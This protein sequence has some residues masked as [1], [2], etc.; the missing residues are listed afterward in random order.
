MPC[1]QRSF[2]QR[3]KEAYTTEL[4]EFITMVRAGRSSDQYHLEQEAI[5]R[6]SS[7]ARITVAAELS[8]KLGR[9]VDLRDLEGLLAEKD[10]GERGADAETWRTRGSGSDLGVK[11][12]SMQS[13]GKW[14]AYLC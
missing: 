5:L 4:T 2:P 8:W 11:C 10:E 7:I 1:A 9:S 12:R 14:I 3:Y 6:H 13:R